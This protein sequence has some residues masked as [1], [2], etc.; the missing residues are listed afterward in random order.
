MQAVNLSYMVMSDLHRIHG[1]SGWALLLREIFLGESFKYIFWMRVCR[2][3]R[4][5]GVSKFLLYPIARLMLRHY[6][7]KYGISIDFTTK[8]GPG[9]Y[10][11]HFGGIVVNDRTVIGRNCNISHAV[12]IGQTNRGRTKG[13]PTLGDDIYI[14]P[15]AKIIGGIRIGNR[16]AIGANAVVTRDV[17][18][19][20]VVVGIPARVVSM[21]GSTD[22]VNCTD[23]GSPSEIQAPP[24]KPPD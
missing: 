21:D 7:F 17:P 4:C 8:I 19:N 2:A 23:Y 13:I 6:R 15:G 16:V 20:A 24:V 9:F 12:T 22:Y 18:D 11:G 1:R 3:A 14:G 5:H 10:I